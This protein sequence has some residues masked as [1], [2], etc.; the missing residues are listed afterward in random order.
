MSFQF[1]A[2]S[3]RW[4]LSLHMFLRGNTC[5][6]ARIPEMILAC[7]VG[8]QPYSAIHLKTSQDLL[9]ELGRGF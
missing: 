4:N 8:V 3:R 1:G 6:N 7:D 5:T 9:I 2:S